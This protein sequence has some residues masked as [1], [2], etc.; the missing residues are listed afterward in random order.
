M[1]SPAELEFPD[2][3]LWGVSTSSYQIE[4]AAREDG[5]GASIWDTRCLMKDRVANG[6]TGDV[7]CDHYHRYPEDIALMQ[8][9]G[10][11][12][13]RFSVAWPRVLPAGKGVVN[14]Q[15]L[16]FY[17]KLID[18]VLEAG[19]EPWL[20][21]YHWDLPQALDDLGGWTSRDSAGWFADYT[22][23]IARRYGDR[24]KRWATF[25]EF[26]VFTLFGYGFDWGAPGSTDRDAHLKA[27]HHAN[28]AHGDAVAVLRA[29]VSGASIGAVHNYQLIVP[30]SQTPENIAAAALLD[31]HWNLAFPD[32]QLRGHYPPMTAQALDH[33]VQPGDLARICQ[34]LDW[35]G[36]NHYGPIFAKADPSMVWG[37]AWG[38]APA[39]MPSTDIG[40][41]IHPEA[42]RDTLLT[43]TER[44]R[45]PIF[46]T[47]NGCGGKDPVAA[48]GTID[49]AG[50][51][52]YL[53]AYIRAMHDAIVRGAD[54]RGYFVWSLLDNF[55]WG[56]GYSNRFGIVHVDFA[57]QKRTPKSS[58]DWYATLARTGRLPVKAVVRDR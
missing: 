48:D 2:H 53:D 37:Y 19:I 10:V 49:D 30:E 57:T 9:L 35:F 7:A 31:E 50:R 22:A 18:G 58:Y 23:L 42:F 5:R 20:C 45:L 14:E 12:A 6:D 16:A 8:R 51:V 26:G 3:F 41:S 55:E 39:D 38:S 36:L 27:M 17:D 28:L 43:L 44:Y 21:L 15:G 33:F 54:V 32:P 47:E 24:V 13:Y 25:N 11:G 52:A 4:G 29:T 46:V 40:W 1:T 56:A 34:P